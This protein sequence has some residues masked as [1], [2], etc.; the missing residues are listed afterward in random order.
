MAGNISI[1]TSPLTP[2]LWKVHFVILGNTYT[3]G[4]SLSSYSPTHTH[5]F[6]AKYW[7]CEFIFGAKLYPCVIFLARNFHHTRVHF[8]GN[9]L[10]TCFLV[11]AQNFNQGFPG[12]GRAIKGLIVFNWMI[13]TNLNMKTKG[14]EKKHLLR[15]KPFL[16]TLIFVYSI[17]LS[18]CLSIYPFSAFLLMRL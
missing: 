16:T 18:I 10:S 7:P 2:N 12:K 1:I 11:L 15:V 6:G 14:R 4:S 13:G 9:I 17:K 8:W 5:V 3:M